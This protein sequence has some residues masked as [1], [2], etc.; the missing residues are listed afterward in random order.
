MPVFCKID[1]CIAKNISPPR[2]S[3]RLRA[4]PRP[5]AH[6]V[7][8]LFVFFHIGPHGTQRICVPS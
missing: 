1:Y 6:V 2:P 3:S 5:G 8:E 7:H 4:E